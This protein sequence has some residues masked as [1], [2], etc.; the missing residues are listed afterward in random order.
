MIP[1]GTFGFMIAVN[2][3]LL[4]KHDYIYEPEPKPNASFQAGSPQRG[5]TSFRMLIDLALMNAIHGPG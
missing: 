4:E 3:Y 5:R 1:P 2:Q